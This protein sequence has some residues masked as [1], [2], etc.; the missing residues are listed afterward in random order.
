VDIVEFSPAITEENFKSSKGEFMIRVVA[1]PVMTSRNV[2]YRSIHSE[3][4]YSV[5]WV[6]KISWKPLTR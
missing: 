5:S 4:I 2:N 3:P 6:A 1:E